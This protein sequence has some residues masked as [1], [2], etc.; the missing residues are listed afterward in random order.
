MGLCFGVLEVVEDGADFG[1]VGFGEVAGFDGSVE[2][3][4]VE[5]SGAI[6]SQIYFYVGCFD[7][8]TGC[9]GGDQLEMV[10]NDSC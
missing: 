6:I 10:G 1:E 9:F 5:A 3:V 7:S 4:P 2:V 8:T